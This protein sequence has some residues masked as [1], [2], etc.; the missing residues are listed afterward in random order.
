MLN[1]TAITLTTVLIALAVLL[2]ALPTSMYA[3]GLSQHQDTVVGHIFEDTNC[4]GIRQ[5]SEPVPPVGQQK[6]IV[7]YSAGNDGIFHTT[8]DMQVTLSGLATDGSGRFVFWV[9][10]S[11]ARA[12]LTILEYDRPEGYEPARLNLRDEGGN[13]FTRPDSNYP[14][15][16]STDGFQLGDKGEPVTVNIGLVKVGTCSD[17]SPIYDMPDPATLTEKAYLPLIVR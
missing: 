13:Y 2:T 12:R 10:N 5:A 4:D 8:D 16:W 14:D 9:G 17:M 3:A 11:K 1:R 6:G 7:M 15:Y